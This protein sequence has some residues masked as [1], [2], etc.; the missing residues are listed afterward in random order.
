M[1]SSRRTFHPDELVARQNAKGLLIFAIVTTIG[2]LINVFN[3]N[4]TYNKSQVGAIFL[5]GVLSILTFFF[6]YKILDSGVKLI[7]NRDG[8]WIRKYNLISWDT[9]EAFYFENRPGRTFK[10]ALRIESK[11]IGQSYT[12]E[13]MLLDKGFDEIIKAI[14]ANSKGFNIKYSGVNTLED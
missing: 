9:I 4:D 1:Q 5:V 11:T 10:S 3:F 7:I 13:I 14:E 2:F 12:I 6:W 8:I